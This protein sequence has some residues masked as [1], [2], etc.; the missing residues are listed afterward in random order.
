MYFC[1]VYGNMT[2]PD[3]YLIFILSLIMKSP[4]E[5]DFYFIILQTISCSI[6]FFLVGEEAQWRLFQIDFRFLCQLF[7]YLR[8]SFHFALWQNCW[9][10]ISWEDELSHVKKSILSIFRFF[11]FIH[12]LSYVM[13]ENDLHVL[14]FLKFPLLFIWGYSA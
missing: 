14:P 1:S 6:Y 11:F 12:N 7:F 2:L 9:V 8:F 13:L 3:L 4:T 10:E 5:D